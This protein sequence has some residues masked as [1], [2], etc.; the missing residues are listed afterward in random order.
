MNARRDAHISPHHFKRGFFYIEMGFEES[1]HE[2]EN[3]QSESH[4][5]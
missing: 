5:C 4:G 3:I 1:I 2:V